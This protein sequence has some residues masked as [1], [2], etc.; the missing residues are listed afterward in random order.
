MDSA[1][2]LQSV[3][4]LLAS[5]VLAIV[6]CRSLRLPPLVGYLAVGV[7]LGPH[8]A[9]LLSDRDELSPLA[10]FGVVFLMFSIGLEFSLPR[11]MAM[12]RVVFGFGAAQVMLTLALALGGAL[13]AGL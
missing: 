3:L 4:V 9:G 7:V 10:H 2:S 8:A 12:R 1:V 6:L 11:L 13:L 5:A